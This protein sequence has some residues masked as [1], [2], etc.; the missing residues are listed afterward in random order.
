VTHPEPLSAARL[1]EQYFL[2]LYPED[3]RLDLGRARSEDANP[4]GNPHLVAQLEEMGEIFAKLAPSALGEPGLE[5][6]FSDASVHR[7]A[8]AL[9]RERREALLQPGGEGEPPALVPFV[10]HGALYLGAC[11][12]RNHGGLWQVRRP[13]WESR[14]RLE[15]RAGTGE[16]AFFH[17]WLKSLSDEEIDSTRLGDRYRAHVE[18]PTA[19]PES[20]PVLAPADRPLPR[21]REARYD[22][23]YKYLRAHLPELRDLGADFPSPERFAELGFQWLDF[24]LVGEGR[25]LLLHGPGSQGVHLFWLDRGGFVKSAFY[26]ADP[27]PAHKVELD[28]EKLRVILPV[29]GKVQVQELLWWGP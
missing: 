11:V 2:P 5:L 3:A 25:N 29:Q 27:F 4:A 18:V 9:T 23:L 19:S 10:L 6:D 15:S 1:F 13:L 21:L 12:T 22:L 20:L 16:L 28:G 14:V 7:L 8:K 17:W 26:P 24:L